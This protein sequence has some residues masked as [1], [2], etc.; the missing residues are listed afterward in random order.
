METLIISIGWMMQVA[1]MPDVPPITKG[2]ITS[3]NFD[4]AELEL[5]GAGPGVVTVVWAGVIVTTTG[6]VV[7]VLVIQLK[8]IFFNSILRK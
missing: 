1:N 5:A 4:T 8:F 7:V 6:P 3:K 2:W